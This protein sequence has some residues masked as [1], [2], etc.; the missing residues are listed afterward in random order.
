M[1]I[2][3]RV[4]FGDGSPDEEA[5]EEVGERA[6]GDDEIK[7]AAV[8]EDVPTDPAT[9]AVLAND[10]EGGSL[11]GEVNPAAAERQVGDGRTAGWLP[12]A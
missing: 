12:P 9:A 11:I 6:I 8:V 2:D 7:P 5:A 3:G 10:P 4:G 1:P